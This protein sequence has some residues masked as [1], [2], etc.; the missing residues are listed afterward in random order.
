M[1]VTDHGY[2]HRVETDGQAHRLIASLNASDDQHC[3]AN[4]PTAIV[5]RY[6][7]TVTVGAM[8]L[9]LNNLGWW[10]ARGSNSRPLH[11]E[12]SALPAELAAQLCG[13][14]SSPLLRR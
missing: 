14:V 7:P 8:L 12:R 1:K 9:Y 2:T 13:A 4:A 3:T 5:Q 6:S 10:T 11:C